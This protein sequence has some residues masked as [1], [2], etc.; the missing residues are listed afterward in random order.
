M[1]IFRVAWVFFRIGLMNEL[2]YRANFFIQIIESMLGMVTALGA[3]FIIFNQ[4]D[5]LAGWHRSEL[6]S[7]LG[8][9]F[10]ILGSIN[11]MISPSLNKFMA[12]I[13]EGKLDFTITK[14]RDAQLLVSVQEFRVWKLLDVVLGM[15]VLSY[16]LNER[17][18]EATALDTLLFLI[19]LLTAAVIIYSFWIILA[20]LAFW[21][22]RIENILQIFW[23][24]YIAGRWPVGIYPAWLKLILTTI[25][26]IAFAVTV[27]AE[28]LAGKLQLQSLA[29]S[30]VLA[31]VL[32]V[33]SRKFWLYGI[34]F[35]S[36]ASA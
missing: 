10:I 20:T 36:G 26:P 18:T 33:A 1:N 13:V 5:T 27:P 24:M 9:Y 4:T 35:Y 34:R 28:A 16:G 15:I 12:D 31:L 7:L 29:T 14:P 23:A 21:F 6:L 30:I 17:L 32:M 22:I 11:L 2:A 25:V 8:I 3:V 19:S